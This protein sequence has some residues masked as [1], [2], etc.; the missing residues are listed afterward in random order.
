MYVTLIRYQEL[1]LS[2]C[3]CYFFKAKHC[4]EVLLWDKHIHF[5]RNW[6]LFRKAFYR[7]WIWAH[8]KKRKLRFQKAVWAL[9]S[10]RS[11]IWT[12]MLGN[13]YQRFKA[14][15]SGF[16]GH[17]VYHH[18]MPIFKMEDLIMKE[19]ISITK[20]LNIILL[21]YRNFDRLQL[22]SSAISFQKHL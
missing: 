22:H 13:A 9:R 16:H 19:S 8:K 21:L 17:T 6:D 7:Y 15:L 18:S 20:T 10:S 12:Q 14:M 4:K 3:M 11:G 1:S 2:L 5:E